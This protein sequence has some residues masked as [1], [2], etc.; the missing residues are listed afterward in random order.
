M[1][2]D[3]FMSFRISNAAKNTAK[4]QYSIH[5][6][7]NYPVTIFQLIMRQMISAHA[8]FLMF[9]LPKERPPWVKFN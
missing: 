4:S 6:A 5:V 3:V 8:L 9:H 1:L 7:V 2:Y